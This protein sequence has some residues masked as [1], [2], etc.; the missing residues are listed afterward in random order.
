MKPSSKL[1]RSTNA[2]GNLEP[3]E[4]WI[5]PRM[6][7]N[8]VRFLLLERSQV[9]LAFTFGFARAHF[10][11]SETSQSVRCVVVCRAVSV[12]LAPGVSHFQ[13]VVLTGPDMRQHR[14]QRLRRDRGF[15]L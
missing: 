5:G 2:F 15:H 12:P 7:S 4:E 8:I 6:P 14:R 1:L 13:S 9:Q 10:N 11:R 3:T